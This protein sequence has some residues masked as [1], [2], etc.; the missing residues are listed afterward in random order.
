MNHA[1]V[2]LAHDEPQ[3]LI[4]T[5]AR[6]C[7]ANH[8]F[9][10]HIDKKNERMLY[11]SEVE[12][13]KY[14]SQVCSLFSFYKTNWGGA[15]LIRAT[16]HMFEIVK[17]LNIERKLNIQRIHLISGKDYPVR[18]NQE[19]D[20]FFELLDVKAY[21][22]FGFISPSSPLTW[23]FNIY[24][25]ADVFD[26]R[27]KYN[28]IPRVF[29]KV[30]L[31]LRSVG[32]IIRKPLDKKLCYGSYWFSCDIELLEWILANHKP[33]LYRFKYTRCCDEVFFH[34]LIMN[35][36]FAGKVLS[37]NYRFVK[38]NHGECCT[39]DESDLDDILISGSVFCRKVTMKDSMLLLDK[40]D[41]II[42]KNGND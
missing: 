18:S 11:T 4:R 7:T 12:K 15:N 37:R 9:F 38:W 1:F 33:L 13:L 30:Q 26:L 14:N 24:H 31:M 5:V 3:L 17:K 42:A 8:F 41:D 6:L 23:R 19:I 22:H 25:L 39:L 34:Y 40:I 2:I 16:L 27:G 36:P 28:I 32:I 29:A 20:T 21:L 35:G 10:I